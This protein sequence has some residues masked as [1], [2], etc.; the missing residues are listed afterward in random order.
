MATS[1]NLLLVGDSGELNP[2]SP[3]AKR[4]IRGAL[5][6]TANRGNIYNGHFNYGFPDRFAFSN[7]TNKLDRIMDYQ[8]LNSPACS[9]YFLLD[10][11]FFLQPAGDLLRND[12]HD[13]YDYFDYAC[14]VRY[15][16]GRFET[17]PI[18]FLFWPFGDL[19]FFGVFFWLRSACVCSSKINFCYFRKLLEL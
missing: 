16:N 14:F 3:W 13:S 18:L 11:L 19:D 8:L 6:N 17:V 4:R 7:W 10:Y 12:S 15:D 9:W 5:S 2:F 1:C